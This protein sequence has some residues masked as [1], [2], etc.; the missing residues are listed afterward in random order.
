MPT[1]SYWLNQWI[2]SGAALPHEMVC[3]YAYA[4]IGAITLSYCQMSRS[5]YCDTCLKVLQKK[6]VFIPGVYIRLDIA[7]FTKMISHWKCL[8]KGRVKEFFIRS[9]ILLVESRTLKQFED[10][11]IKMSVIASSETDGLECSTIIPTPFEKFCC[12]IINM[13]KYV[14]FEYDL[15]LFS[16]DLNMST[17][18]DNV[19]K[20]KNYSTGKHMSQYLTDLVCKIDNHCAVE[21]NRINAYYVPELKSNLNRIFKDF[22]M[23]RFLM[24]CLI[25]LNQN[26]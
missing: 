18:N 25:I 7:Y 3:D 5:D 19:I 21:G 4:L 17:I 6:E 8:G 20:D 12:D 2:K 26:S 23:W 9:L 22:P 16:E 14:N 10:T 1:I 24:L 11:F 15:E 13:I